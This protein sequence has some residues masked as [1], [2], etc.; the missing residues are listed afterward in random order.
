MTRLQFRHF[1]FYALGDVNEDWGT[2]T[3]DLHPQEEQ[4]IMITIIIIIIMV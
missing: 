3:S 4:E 1:K 2:R